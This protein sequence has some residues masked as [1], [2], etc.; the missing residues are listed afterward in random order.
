MDPDALLNLVDTFAG[1]TK[2]MPELVAHVQSIQKGRVS[3]AQHVRRV[4]MLWLLVVEDSHILLH[5]MQTDEGLALLVLNGLPTL[6]QLGAVAARVAATTLSPN[7][8]HHGPEAWYH[9]HPNVT[10]L[11]S[12]LSCPRFATFERAVRRISPPSGQ[13]GEIDRILL[14]GSLDITEA[15]LAEKTDAEIKARRPSAEPA[16]PAIELPCRRVSVRTFLPE[17]PGA[18]EPGSS[19]DPLPK[20]LRRA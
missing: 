1:G 3:S 11:F 10:T 16:E 14:H 15:A 2:P 20:R 18:S 7:H 17:P 12:P 6:M 19:Q 13:M 9:A 4:L 5:K 8:P